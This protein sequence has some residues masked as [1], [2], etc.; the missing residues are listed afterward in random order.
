MRFI[1]STSQNIL[2]DPI[3]KQQQTKFFFNFSLGGRDKMYLRLT[4]TMSS[5]RRAT[6]SQAQSS[7]SASQDPE[8]EPEE[9]GPS[10]YPSRILDRPVIAPAVSRSEGA[11]S[12]GP[13]PSQKRKLTIPNWFVCRDYCIS[14]YDKE[15]LH[16]S[17]L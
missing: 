11:S 15:L 3:H 12:T 7:P 9:Q 17:Q 6:R 2:F 16:V 5:R 13:A 1:Q 10:T 4:E 8:F 14:M